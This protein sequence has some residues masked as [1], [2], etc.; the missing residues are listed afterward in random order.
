MTGAH[1]RPSSRQPGRGR[2]PLVRICARSHGF[3][4]HRDHAGSPICRHLPGAGLGWAAC[5]P[6]IQHVSPKAQ[7]TGPARNPTA[8]GAKDPSARDPDQGAEV[9]VGAAPVHGRGVQERA[10][11]GRRRRRGSLTARPRRSRATAGCARAAGAHPSRPQPAMAT[12][13]REPRVRGGGSR[14]S[15]RA[16]AAGPP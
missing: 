16:G 6:M 7:S 12:S 8:T 3:G 9:Q 5:P 1:R 15:A 4:R 2:L 13:G 10:L 11:R 14:R